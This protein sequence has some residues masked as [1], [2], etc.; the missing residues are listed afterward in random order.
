M[1]RDDE[2]Y[3][4]KRGDYS[5]IIM[6]V[7]PYNNGHLMVA[8]YRHVIYPNELSSEESL[9]IFNFISLAIDALRSLYSPDGFNVGVNIG[10]AAGAGCEHLHLHVVPRWSGDT[11]FMP[12]L[13]DVK[14]ISQHLRAT[15]DEL[16]RVIS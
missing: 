9:E 14:V 15:F 13:G 5:Y 4:L 8:P 11:N 2:F 16:K 3:I 1:D 6:N 7:Y 12:V 10:R